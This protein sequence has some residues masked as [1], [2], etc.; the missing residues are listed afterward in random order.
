MNPKLKRI[1]DEAEDTGR[2]I[3]IGDLVVCDVCDEDFTN[4]PD[5]GGLIF[6]SYAY[7]PECTK[8]QRPVIKKYGEEHMIRAVARDGQS[9]ADFVRDYRGP[10]A[11]IHFKKGNDE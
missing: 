2:P 5:V 11:A 7:C 3:E 1:W 10:D 6:G 8:R 9:F 4:R